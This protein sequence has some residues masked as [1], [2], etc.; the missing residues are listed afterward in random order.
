M[1]G[2]FDVAN[3]KIYFFNTYIFIDSINIINI[4]LVFHTK[5]LKFSIYIC[6]KSKHAVVL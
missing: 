2:S 5:D 4:I 1:M 3:N 6:L